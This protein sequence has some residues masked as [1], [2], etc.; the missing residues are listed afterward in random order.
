M[1]FISSVKIFFNYVLKGYKEKSKIVIKEIY[2]EKKLRE[3]HDVSVRKEIKDVPPPKKHLLKKYTSE[4]S[5]ISTAFEKRSVRKGKNSDP[6]R[7]NISKPLKTDTKQIEAFV[8]EPWDY[9]P[10]MPP[11][12]DG[13]TRFNELSLSLSVLRGVHEIGFSYC[14]DIQAE[15]LPHSLKGLDVAGKAQT[16]TGKTAAFL[17]TILEHLLCKKLQKK[18]IYGA[19]RALIMAP[20]RELV[21]QIEKDAAALSKYCGLRIL[22]IFGGIDYEKQR[23]ALENCYIDIMIATPGRLLDYFKQKIIRL[24]RVE[25]LVLD[26]ADRMLDMGFLPDMR[27]IIDATPSKNERQT[28]LFSAT[29]TPEITRLASMWTNNPVKVEIEPEQVTPADVEQVAYIV[30][31]HDKFALLYNL[32]KNLNVRRA[33]IFAN[34]RDQVRKLTERLDACDFACGMLTGDV[35]QAKRIKTLESLKNGKINILVATDVAGRGIH[36]ADVEA[37]FNYTLPDDPDDYVHRIGRTG[38]AGAKGRS[39]SFASEEDAYVLPQIEAYIKEPLKYIT[40]D[41]KLLTPIPEEYE[42][43]LKDMKRKRNAMVKH[44]KHSGPPKRKVSGKRR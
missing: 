3:A 11:V 16:G 7:K 32:L 42:N 38:R 9:N 12:R 30:T 44:T 29:L 1:V 22:A 39:I 20:T 28:M 37:V 6:S 15:I 5:E 41:E 10:H 18:R 2:P 14:T 17:L 26:E 35:N 31:E 43:R 27:R 36:V 21:M 40:P 34:R 13:K 24:D 23:D 19:P 8:P 25:I 33:I 4:E